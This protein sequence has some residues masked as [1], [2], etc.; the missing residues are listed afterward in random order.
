MLS[1]FATPVMHPLFY[2]FSSQYGLREGLR[3]RCVRILYVIGRTLILRRV[4]GIS[5]NETLFDFWMFGQQVVVSPWKIFGLIGVMMFT[6]RWFV[7]AYYSR[8]AGKPVTPRIFWWMSIAGSLILLSYFIFSGK[9]DLVGVMSNLFP[10]VISGYNLYLDLTH[11]K[12]TVAEA[13]RVLKEKSS[14][15][16]PVVNTSSQVE[17]AKV[18]N[19]DVTDSVLNA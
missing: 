14:A 15:E 6:G 7:Q 19:V 3:L 8:K 9:R 17:N 11:A 1:E 5:M 4:Q 16:L 10:C 12:K 18:E 13:E 2:Y